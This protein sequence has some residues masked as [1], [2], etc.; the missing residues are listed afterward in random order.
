M[1]LACAGGVGPPLFRD[2]FCIPPPT[3]RVR[4]S[5]SVC[6]KYCILRRAS[7]TELSRRELTDELL[8][9]CRMLLAAAMRA[10]SRSI[11]R[12]RSLM[13]ASSL[14]VKGRAAAAAGWW[15]RGVGVFGASMAGCCQSRVAPRPRSSGRVRK[16]DSAQWGGESR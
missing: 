1:R 3:L 4:R 7:L 13:A 15:V 8:V 10:R 16:C 11:L 5:C 14:I 6:S 9:A 2:M 12:W